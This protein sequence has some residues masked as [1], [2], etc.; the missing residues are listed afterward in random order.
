MSTPQKCPCGREIVG[1]TGTCQSGHS[2]QQQDKMR[3]EME[4]SMIRQ[5]E[6]ANAPTGKL[7]AD[8]VAG[9]P[10]PAA[11]PEAL[12]RGAM[13]ERGLK[14]EPRKLP[15]SRESRELR[16]ELRGDAENEKPPDS[17][18]NAEVDRLASLR[19][20]EYGQQRADASREWGI[21][22]TI[23]D[24]A[25]K[26]ARSAKP[27][28]GHSDG[29]QGKAVLFADP[30][31]LSE[32]EAREL[33]GASLLQE[34]AGTLARHLTLPS[35]ADT[36][37]ALWVLFTWLHDAFQISPGLAI[38]SPEKG[39]GKTSLLTLLGALV[40]KPLLVANVT[41]ASLFRRVEKDSP[42]LLVDEADTF[43]HAGDE[44]RGILNAGWLRSSAFVDRTVGDDFEPR[45]FS[46]WCPK[47]LAAIGN[48]PGTL[49]D[50]SIEVRMRRQTGEEQAKLKPLR[51]DRVYLELEP[52][53]RQVF[54]WTQGV[55]TE[56]TLPLRDPGL[57]E[58]FTNRLG[59]NW[60]VLFQIAEV[61][62]QE[63]PELVRD[64]AVAFATKEREESW[65]EM[66]LSDAIA[67]LGE[68]EEGRL[69]S[70]DL[71]TYLSTMEERPWPECVKGR[72][73]TPRWLAHKL[74][75]FGIKPKP[76]RVDNAVVKG[77][78]KADF[79]EPFRR[80]C[81]KPAESNAVPEGAPSE[82]QF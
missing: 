46:V 81:A 40:R 42:T 31:P 65:G 19:L 71:A 47:A 11:K 77:Y 36:V 26:Q 56:G 27:G 54:T 58:G 25:V 53:R 22:L 63:W 16:A 33:N 29:K 67:R 45:L 35:H 2:P 23:L 43:I 68:T 50:R 74:S 13:A 10:A 75:A 12:T 21:P 66:L 49:I 38:T 61:A 14:L 73:I 79:A 30:E 17:A 18:I 59:D 32:A 60:R 9:T 1:R 3:R 37:L 62:G 82:S 80:Y 48:L 64:A 7:G 24:R 70:V 34:V 41:P 55:L 44:L 8:P 57:P 69:S 28:A 5:L 20:V 76:I 6:R 51:A 4:E 52:L 72:P 78:E 39:C 15:E